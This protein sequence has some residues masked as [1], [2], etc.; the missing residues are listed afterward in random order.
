MMLMAYNVGFGEWRDGSRWEQMRKSVA[1]TVAVTAPGG[2]E[3]FQFCLPGLLRSK[4]IDTL[5][6]VTENQ[7]Y[8]ELKASYIWGSIE[9]KLWYS[10]FFCVIK[11]FEDLERHVWWQRLYGLLSVCIDLGY[12]DHVIFCGGK[13][14]KEL[15]GAA[16]TAGSKATS[17]KRREGEG[18]G[19]EK[20]GALRRACGDAGLRE[21]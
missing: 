21:R 15:K 4:K 13:G 20:A 17:Q 12:F 1:D 7:L 2:D 6:A 9:T 3:L 5:D 11:R 8:Q 19:T 18:S 10:R 16:A 14:K